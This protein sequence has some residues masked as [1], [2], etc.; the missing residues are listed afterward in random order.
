MRLPD[1]ESVAREN[2]G[3]REVR[4]AGTHARQPGD[5]HQRRSEDRDVAPRDREHVVGAGLLQPLFGVVV[6]SGPVAQQDR[7][8][9]G[10]GTDAVDANPAV[11]DPPDPRPQLC[12]GFGEG[13]ALATT[14][15]S[16][17]LLTLP[18]SVV[19]RSASAASSFP[20]PGFR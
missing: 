5:G 15:T 16:I 2:D 18:T 11:D 6:E 19:P 3:N 10:R 7:A 4:G 14:C 13:A 9:D 8:H 17:A 20:A 12:G 1:Q